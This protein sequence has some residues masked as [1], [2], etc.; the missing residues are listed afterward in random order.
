[1]CSVYTRL[2]SAKEASLYADDRLIII[3]WQEVKPLL[4]SR[5]I[6]SQLPLPADESYPCTCA[7]FSAAGRQ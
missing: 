7:R 4:F 1:M 6:N 5:K 2:A 3:G